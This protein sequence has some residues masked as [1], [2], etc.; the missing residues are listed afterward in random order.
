MSSNN[1]GSSPVRLLSDPNFALCPDFSSDAF[2]AVREAMGQTDDAAAIAKLTEGWAKS[3]DRDKAQWVIQ[4]EADRAQERA[5]EA[6]R[7]QE[8]EAA[9]AEVL[10][11]AEQERLDA[12]KKIP[13]LGDFDD[14][15][16]PS[17]F[18]EARISAFAQKKIDSR[19][20]CPLW[21]FTTAGLA[22]AAAAVASSGDDASS[23]RLGRTDDNQLTVQSGPSSS[24][25]KSMVRDENLPYREFSLGW[26]RYVKELEK[27]GWPQAHITAISQFFFGLETHSFCEQEHGDKI[28]QIYADRYRLEWFN[29]L[30]KPNAFNL[31]IIDEVLLQKIANEHLMKL[32]TKAIAS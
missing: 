18:V 22:E 17:S 28:I 7:Q 13:K 2:A 8:E 6:Q 19:Q 3:N 21:P 32:H 5:Q 31:A 11:L 4:E 10:K 1:N 20:Y 15:R 26:H 23:I 30:G 27:A 9:A 25:H 16:A 24:T 12:E 14:N 29:T